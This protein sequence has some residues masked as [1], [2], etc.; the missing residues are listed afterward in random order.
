MKTDNK[1]LSLSEF[2]TNYKEVPENWAIGFLELRDQLVAKCDHREE[3]LSLQRDAKAGTHGDLSMFLDKAYKVFQQTSKISRSIKRSKKGTTLHTETLYLIDAEILLQGMEICKIILPNTREEHIES[4]AEFINT[5]C[6]VNDKLIETMPQK[7]LDIEW[8]R[9]KHLIII[10]GWISLLLEIQ[11]LK[12]SFVSI[13]EN[14]SIIV[15]KCDSGILNPRLV[16][17][18]VNI[19]A[20]YSEDRI[21]LNQENTWIRGLAIEKVRFVL[22]EIFQY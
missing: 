2:L 5:L 18:L 6:Y 15:G 1:E 4:F 10:K 16:E 13:D 7:S 3:I 9:G 19:L 12:S 17:N 21:P 8:Y 14:Y 22:K 20:L 11:K